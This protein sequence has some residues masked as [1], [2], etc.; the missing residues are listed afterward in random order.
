MLVG[1]RGRGKF[2][3]Y[4]PKKP[5]KYGVKEMILA[6]SKTNYCYHAHIFCGRGGGLRW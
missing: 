4:T 3:M 6:D 2:K 1:F 5:N